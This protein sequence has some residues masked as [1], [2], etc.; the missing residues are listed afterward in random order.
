MSTLNVNDSNI[1]AAAA[2]KE[3]EE[4]CT[5]DKLSIDELQNMLNKYKSLIINNADQHHSSV[6]FHQAC[7]NKNVTLDIIQELLIYF[8]NAVE[9][10]G[11]YCSPGVV[12]LSQ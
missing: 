6:L 9:T 3:L 8:P 2:L 4:L 12:N 10:L 5:S 1:S 11:A 7:M